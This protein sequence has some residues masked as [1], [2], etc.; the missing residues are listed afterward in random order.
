MSAAVGMLLIFGL[1]L[2]LV[3]GSVLAAWLASR[4]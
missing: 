4:E 1:F 3:V 2:I